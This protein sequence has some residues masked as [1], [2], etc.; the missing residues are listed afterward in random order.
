MTRSQL[1]PPQQVVILTKPKL[2]AI[3]GAKAYAQLRKEVEQAGILKRSYGFYFL[4]TL[5][6][7]LGFVGSLIAFFVVGK[8]IVLILFAVLAGFFTVQFGGLM[9]DAGHRAIFSSPRFNDLIGHFYSA[10]AIMSFDEW[11]EIH[12]R[13]HA[14]PN[15]ENE[16]PDVGIIFHSFTADQLNKRKGLGYFLTRF[17][18]VLFY[19]IRT[20]AF[21]STRL[22]S[23]SYFT[24]DPQ[25]K[26]FPKAA[27]FIAGIIVWF[28]LPFLVFSPRKAI[29]FTIIANF[30]AGFYSSNIFAPNH[31]GMPVIEN[32]A[33]FSFL[34]QQIVTARN[35]FPGRITDFIYVGL[36]YQIEHHLF[37]ACPRNKLNLLT[38]FVKKV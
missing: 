18:T 17:Q 20:F 32:G 33:K 34:E 3:D 38:P 8:P 12:N 35:V 11:K 19:P 28:V 9:H 22:G 15:E 7:T 29:I 37:P 13:H 24:K 26:K 31:K 1:P 5:F 27:V 21:L 6:V 2:S 14:N 25:A 30:T 36:N 10:F 23:I 16:D 4:M